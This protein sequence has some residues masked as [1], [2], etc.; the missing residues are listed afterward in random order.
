[1]EFVLFL[2]V[3]ALIVEVVSRR[4]KEAGLARELKKLRAD[5]ERILDRMERRWADQKPTP[6]AEVSPLGAQEPQ[7]KPQHSEPVWP[8]AA[9]APAPPPPRVAAPEPEPIQAAARIATPPPP[10]VE[11]PI[12][13]TTMLPPPGPAPE[14]R[15][16]PPHESP[17]AFLRRIDWESKIGVY[18]FSVVAA[19]AA[20]VAAVSFVSYSLEHGLLGPSARMAIG[21]VTGLGLLVACE[22]QRAQR[23][24][25]TA[26]A[27]TA[28]GIVTL[29]S[30]FFAS[31]VLWHLIGSYTTFGLLIL[32]TA[33][34]VG[35]SIRR[36]ALV[37]ALLGLLGGFTTPILLSTGENNPVGLFGYLLMLDLG[38]A[39]VAYKK[40]WPILAGLSLAFTGLYQAGWVAKFFNAE[41]MPLAIG[42]FLL[43]PLV[44]FGT[45]I[46]S[47][48]GQP[49]SPDEPPLFARSAPLAAVPPVLFSL[50]LAMSPECG[51]H[52]WLLFG[53]LFAVALGLALV[54]AFAGPEW[55]HLAGAG[56]VLLTFVAFL[57]RSYSAEAWPSILLLVAL[58]VAL[59]LG[60]PLLVGWLRRPFAQQAKLG[61]YAAPLLLFAFPV[62][63]GIE[64]RSAEPLLFFGVLFLLVAALATY[65]VLKGDGPVHF[66]ASALVLAAEAIWSAY[67]LDSARLLPALLVYGGF[68]LFYL[69][70]PILAE[71]RGKPLRPEGSGAIVLF[72][73]LGLLFFLAAGPAAQ[74]SLWV[75]AVLLGV[76]NLGLLYEASR[77]RHPILA[78]AG[79]VL[80][81][82]VVAVWWVS[83][84]ALSV[85]VPA[86]AVMAG[87]SILAMGGSI[88]VRR[89]IEREALAA[90]R[91]SGQGPFLGLA[92]HVFL[93]AVVLQP[94]LCPSPWP[95]LAVMAVLD[96]AVGIAAIVSNRA[97]LHLSAVAASVVVLL[98]WQLRLTS[99]GLEDG[100]TPAL[101]LAMAVA[102]VLAAFA[103]AWVLFA[104]RRGLARRLF[105]ISAGVALFGGVLVVA[106]TAAAGVPAGWSSWTL[107]L[108]TLAAD[109]L[110]LL[111]VLA[112]AWHVQQQGWTLGAA[113]GMAVAVMAW[114]TDRTRAEW[115]Q[116]LALSAPLYLVL[117]ANPLLLRQRARNDRLP[118]LAAL[119][120][121]G[122]FFFFGRAALMT[123]GAGAAIGLLPVTQAV[124]LVPHLR[125][126]LRMETPSQRDVGRLA[127]MAGG[128]L[129]FVTVAIPLQL[130]KQW[131]TLGWA[132]LAL[133]LAWLH[134]RV[135]HRGILWWMASLLSVVLVRLALNPSVLEYRE[136]RGPFLL[137]WYL[138][139]YVIAAGCFFGA[140]WLLR[141]QDDRLLP[142]WPRLSHV[143]PAPGTV[144]LFL[145]LNLEIA[146]F[147]SD[148]TR[149][150]F[151]FSAGLA[152]DLTYTIGWGL[153]AIGLLAAGVIARS[154][155]ARITSIVLL[156]VTI[157]KAF[158]HDLSHLEDLYRVASFVGLAV[159]LLLVA[160][161]LQRFV[162]Q[163]SR[164]REEKRP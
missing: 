105:A 134:A 117:L 114:Y 17:L 46:L 28:A 44:G 20:I 42:I 91:A 125:L 110:L 81:W 103:L 61:V 104:E 89:R 83:A 60:A 98:A 149:I 82:I 133:A 19:I 32:V 37:I 40:R 164:A 108:C 64:P 153:F 118:F 156:V 41:Q 14:Q 78:F 10:N 124:L 95:W 137:D 30:T 39:W 100:A 139:T 123:A 147:F 75:M 71:R 6:A 23:Y 54:A 45:L 66:L 56:T 52:L 68:G 106:Q 86:L 102:V 38:L 4:R 157:L 77:G 85:M 155:V 24:R 97:A 27:M 2:V 1:M 115:A 25:I 31:H 160:V 69:G 8:P 3:V 150:V 141:D 48:R 144:L 99:G 88:W 111:G 132:L 140:A 57:G 15:P 59:Y 22:T 63:A 94:N 96:L 29:F 154:K 109:L 136:Q 120:A 161:V 58:F 67:H 33:V 9:E 36:N 163:G 131:I 92:G 126:L 93:V 84:I 34:A 159:C 113:V 128:V 16:P 11:E 35:L 135:P 18:A 62:L 49:A 74:A 162:L 12:L 80:S 26:H 73:S 107:L 72:A 13:S 43:F 53:F 70:V 121:S 148:G 129:A 119:V 90:P 51:A 145:L 47:R 142:R 101:P 112:L 87:F 127:M 76:L 55:L 152:T 79:L 146:G 7:P 50:Y 151:Q 158:L 21:I 65:A 143:L 130:E 116:L 138:Y 122:A 5:Q